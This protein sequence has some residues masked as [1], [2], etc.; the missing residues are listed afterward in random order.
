MNF[1]YNGKILA[2]CGEPSLHEVLMNLSQ[3]SFEGN[4]ENIQISLNRHDSAVSA[5]RIFKT[6]EKYDVTIKLVIQGT[7]PR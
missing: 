2:Y 4:V 1:T 7:I 5:D 3:D 6:Y